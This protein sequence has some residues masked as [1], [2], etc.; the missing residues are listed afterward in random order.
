MGGRPDWTRPAPDRGAARHDW[1]RSGADWRD[2]VR[3]RWDTR[4]RMEWNRN[5][6]RDSRYDYGRYRAQNRSLYRLPLYYAP[7]SWSYGYRRFGIGFTLSSIL[8]DQSYWID[9]PISYRLPPAYGPYRW[10]RYYNDALLV[11]VRSG[12]VVDAIYDIFW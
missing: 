3:D 9:D 6:R 4:D 11:D 10:V 8:F 2:G 7:S 1:T 5:W 12:Q